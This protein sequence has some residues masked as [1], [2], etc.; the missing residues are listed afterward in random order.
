MT[1]RT[2]EEARTQ[3]I[4]MVREF[5]RRDVE[6]IVQ[7]YERNDIVPLE[8]VEKMKEMGLFGITIPEEYG[9]M[10]LDYTTFAM[11]FEELCKGWM[12]ISGI[13]GTHHIMTYV[14]THY[15]TEEQKARF[16]PAMARGEKRGGLA[17]HRAQRRKRCPGHR[18]DGNPGRRRVP[19]KRHQDVHH[20]WAA[21]GH[22]RPDNQDQ[23]GRYSSSRGDK[24]LH[25]RKGGKGL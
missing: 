13:I 12:S 15:G 9:G 8:L 4:N 7:E 2:P 23:Q 1:T 21:R 19:D 25:R 6:P 16:L 20:Q 17:L 18:A 14:V 3:I 5:V 24:L 22:I 10:G 11:I